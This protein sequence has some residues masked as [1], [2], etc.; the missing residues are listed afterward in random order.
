MADPE[1]SERVKTVGPIKLIKLL[2]AM[3]RQMRLQRQTDSPEFVILNE[4]ASAVANLAEHLA[5]SHRDDPS[6]VDELRQLAGHRRHALSDALKNFKRQGLDLEWRLYNQSARLIQAAMNKAPVSPEDPRLTP[7]LDAVQRLMRLQPEECFAELAALEPRLHAVQESVVVGEA[8]RERPRSL[9][10]LR[11]VAIQ[12]LDTYERLRPLLGPARPDHDVL[13]STQ[14][15]LDLVA[16][17]LSR[18]LSGDS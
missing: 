10:E 15:A 12:H 9:D 18:S 2:I 6:A 16:A 1:A 4:R 11:R 13:L 7:R 5:R 8:P 3:R 17:F 14:T